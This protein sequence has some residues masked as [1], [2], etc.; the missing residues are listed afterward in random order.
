MTKIQSKVYEDWV[1]EIRDNT[2]NFYQETEEP[3]DECFTHI[4][5]SEY[6]EPRIDIVTDMG[7]ETTYLYLSDEF[8]FSNSSDHVA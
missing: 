7:E 2:I 6:E 3:E 8:V 1:W 4:E 5:E